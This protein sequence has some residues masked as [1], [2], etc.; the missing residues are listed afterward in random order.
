MHDH[1]EK[2]DGGDAHRGEVV[3]VGPPWVCIVDGFL[4]GGRVVVEGVFAG[5]YELDRVLEL[6][7]VC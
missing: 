7:A 2:G 4:G 3:G 6:W 1:L 5:V